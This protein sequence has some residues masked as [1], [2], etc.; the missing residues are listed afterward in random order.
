MLKLHYEIHSLWP[1]ANHFAHSSNRDKTQDR[2]Q[3]HKHTSAGHSRFCL[4]CVG[5][6]ISYK[7]Q[8]NMSTA[9]S[10]LP[11]STSETSTRLRDDPLREVSRPWQPGWGW[12]SCTQGNVMTKQHIPQFSRG[13]GKP[14]DR[15]ASLQC[16]PAQCNMTVCWPSG[17]SSQL[18]NTRC[19]I[20]WPFKELLN[21]ATLHCM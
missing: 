2:R 10:F 16:I 21:T 4:H 3:E 13:W 8:W 12:L 1:Q 5:P 20:I 19:P 14:L 7:M 15:G 9:P 17:T 18:A 6:M 11:C